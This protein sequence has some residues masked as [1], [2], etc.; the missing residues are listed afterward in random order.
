MEYRQQYLCPLCGSRNVS[1]H[2]RDS[3]EW[4]VKYVECRC[5]SCGATW[6]Q[7]YKVVFDKNIRVKDKDGKE[8]D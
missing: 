4:E 2:N 8:I 3:W 7:R 5:C 1:Y 6:T